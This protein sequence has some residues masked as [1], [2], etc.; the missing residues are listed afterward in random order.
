MQ[1]QM[2]MQTNSHKNNTS[3]PEVTISCNNPF[4]I[5]IREMCLRFYNRKSSDKSQGQRS[6][7]RSQYGI[8]HLQPQAISTTK[9]LRPTRL[10]IL[11]Y[12]LDKIFTPA[13]LPNHLSM[14]LDAMGE[15]NIGIST[16][17]N[18]NLATPQL[19]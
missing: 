18:H 10:P 17:G 2:H 19:A 7:L 6:D 14:Q 16:I 1:K 4:I 13:H 3:L 11:R 15:S 8:A 12:R 9:Y 5:V